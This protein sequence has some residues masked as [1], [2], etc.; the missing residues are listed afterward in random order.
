MTRA[1]G[2]TL[3]ANAAAGTLFGTSADEL[4]YR[5]YHF[6]VDDDDPRC[7]TLPAAHEQLGGIC[8]R[9]RMR[10]KNGT[11][12]EAN[13]SMVGVQ[14]ISDTACSLLIVCDISSR[15]L[16][17]QLF[18]ESEQRRHFALDAAQIG[19]WE[20]DL[21]TNL[22]RRSL[23]HD[24]CFGYT[25]PV[26]KWSYQIFLQHVHVD[27][28]ARV[29]AVFKNAMSGR[30]PYDVEFRV[31]WPDKTIHWL[32]S[33]GRFTLDD[34]G[35]PIRICGIQVDVTER[36][37]QQEAL[38]FLANHDALTGLPNRHLLGECLSQEVAYATQTNTPMAVI[39]IDVDRFKRFND[40]MGHGVGDDILKEVSHRLAIAKRSNDTVGRLGGDEFLVICPSIDRET[41]RELAENFRRKLTLPIIWHEQEVVPT[42]SI[43]IALFPRDGTHDNEL[44]KNADLAMYAA[45][46]AGRNRCRFYSSTM[47]EN[48]ECDLTIERE[49][50]RALLHNQVYLHYQPQ[51]NLH[52]GKLT[53]I[54]ALARWHHP[55]L[56]Q[57]APISFIRVAENN[58]LIDLLGEQVL[59]Q[60]CRQN[61][62]WISSGVCNVQMA[63]NVSALQFREPDFLLKIDRIL[64]DTGLAANRLEIELTESVV[65]HSADTSI[66][67]L[68]ALRERGLQL[69]IDDFG[70][71]YSSLSYLQQ[72]PLNRLKVDRSFIIDILDNQDSAA[73]TK[74]IV[75]LSHSLGFEVVAEGIEHDD[76]ANLLRTLG[77]DQAQG[78]FFS[79]PLS[80]DRLQLQLQ[81]R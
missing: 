10:K 11:L 24:Q 80:A 53:G 68:K 7:L 27:D 5:S 76:Q 32:W 73:I 13:I 63:V 59:R 34:D 70:T 15:I 41:A 28:R 2:F 33:K 72:F 81:H 21:R 14:T 16:A 67:T 46:A 58:G 50:R 17:D 74:A 36:R 56:G 75:G 47:H 4:L 25:T 52:S 60:A 9:V 55:T 29:D 65:M 77:C 44:L 26:A 78:N 8:T 62:A 51:F 64:H 45:K 35:E 54:E 6:L 69:A 18:D 57:I 20:L 12:F 39:F 48:A 30:T 22:A 49:L 3:Y 37:Q 66:D 19:D 61:Q 1:D 40:A 79:Q 38:T 71:G 23:R 31:V 42:A 43:G